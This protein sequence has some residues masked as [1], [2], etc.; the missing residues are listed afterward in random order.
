MSASLRRVL[1]NANLWRK[2]TLLKR[3]DYR[4]IKD[5]Q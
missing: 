2:V 4:Q 1:L 5:E 3:E